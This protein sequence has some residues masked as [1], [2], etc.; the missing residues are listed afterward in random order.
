MQTVWRTLLALDILGTLLVF[1]LTGLGHES[2]YLHAQADAVRWD[3]AL[4]DL[5]VLSAARVSIYWLLFD[6]VTA[7]ATAR[8]RDVEQPRSNERFWLAIII[9]CSVVSFIYTVVKS[10]FIFH[11]GPSQYEGSAGIIAFL[12]LALVVVT[13]EMLLAVFRLSAYFKELVR[14]EIQ[15]PS[16]NNSADAAPEGVKKSKGASFMRLAKQAGP[17]KWI[18]FAGL[19]CLVFSSGANIASPYFFGEIINA[20]STGHSSSGMARNIIILGIIY[21]IGSVASF[22]RVYLFTLA[23]QRFVARLRRLLFSAIVHQEIAFFDQNRTGEL[24]NRLASDTAVVQDSLT[25]NLAMLVNY[26]LQVWRHR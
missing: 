15:S 7:L 26:T 2:G 24:T 16:I 6:T 21:T 1:F 5:V 8:A 4:I 12:V 17:E 20:A 19:F 14:K 10:A 25:M 23:G 22:F 3:D 11:N 18:L 9:A 13:L